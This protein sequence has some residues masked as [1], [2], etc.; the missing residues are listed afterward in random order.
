MVWVA[1]SHRI[2]HPKLLFSNSGRKRR[3][4]SS[5]R[6]RPAPR[7]APP[8]RGPAAPAA[9][10]RAPPGCRPAAPSASSQRRRLPSSALSPMA[11]GGSNLSPPCLHRTTTSSGG[12]PSLSREAHPCSSVSLRSSPPD[13]PSSAVA[14]SAQPPAA[15]RGLRRR[16]GS[17]SGAMRRSTA[18]AATRPP[19]RPPPR[20]RCPTQLRAAAGR[21][22][23]HGSD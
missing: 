19:R 12:L 11:D 9:P 21:V 20:R 10:R 17:S 15:R 23:G 22:E 3:H 6:R 7:R 16:A 4:V 5:P 13:P 18:A 1:H 14:P 8:R 2:T